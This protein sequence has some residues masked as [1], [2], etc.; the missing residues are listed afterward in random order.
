MRHTG[1][2]RTTVGIGLV[3][4]AVVAGTLTLATATESGAATPTTVTFAEPPQTPPNYIFPFMSLAF[5]SVSNSEQFQYLMYRP[6]YWFGN[7]ATPNLNP[8]LSLAQQPTYST[9]NTDGHPQPQA[10]Q[11]VER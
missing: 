1:R 10:L 4:A 7:G 3:V 8:S 2:I 6:L 9:D 5:F 11:V